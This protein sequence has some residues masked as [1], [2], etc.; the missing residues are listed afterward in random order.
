MQ[1][2]TPFVNGLVLFVYQDQIF[3][4]WVLDR[5]QITIHWE[6]GKALN[7]DKGGDH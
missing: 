7:S 3:K 6:E 2:K 5:N 4:I 1:R